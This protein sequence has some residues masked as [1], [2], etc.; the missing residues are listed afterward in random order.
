MVLKGGIGIASDYRAFAVLLWRELGEQPLAGVHLQT[1]LCHRVFIGRAPIG[2][3]H[4]IVCHRVKSGRFRA[5]VPFGIGAVRVEVWVE[6]PRWYA[7]IAK[8]RAYRCARRHLCNDG[9][10]CGVID[11]ARADVKK[12]A[13][14]RERACNESETFNRGTG[15]ASRL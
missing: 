11:H 6:I 8:C 13:E 3:V 7:V 9:A 1:S 14:L 2:N 10:K 12:P 4:C 15:R 5:R